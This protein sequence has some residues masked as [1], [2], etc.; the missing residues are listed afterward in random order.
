MNIE[1]P[2]EQS[3]SAYIEPDVSDADSAVPD[4]A[5]TTYTESL[6]SSLLQS[7]RENGRG[8]HKY[9][10]STYFVPEDEQ[11]QERLDMQHEI[12][13]MSTNRK[14]YLAT[15]NQTMVEGLNRVGREGGLPNRYKA[16]LAET[17]F[18]DVAEVRYK[19]PQNTWPKYKHLK[20]IGEWNMVNTLDG[21]HGF[22]ARLCIQVMGM[23]PEELEVLLAAC[24]KDITN[25]KIHSYWSMYVPCLK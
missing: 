19:W 5:S 4:T 14:L 6:R 7:V 23:N 20:K 21:L 22:A 2:P 15:L 9:S 10:S 11:E 18:K 3:T 8:Y 13:L 25:P 17:G 16:L 1:I 12:C 24:R